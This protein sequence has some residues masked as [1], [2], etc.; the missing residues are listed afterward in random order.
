MLTNNSSL[1]KGRG[2]E[3]WF[4][5]VPELTTH[6]TRPHSQVLPEDGARSFV[7]FEHKPESFP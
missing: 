2:T 4:W 7:A 6:D 5:L 1:G 3:H